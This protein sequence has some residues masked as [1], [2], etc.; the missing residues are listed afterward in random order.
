MRRRNLIFTF[1][2]VLAGTLMNMTEHV[3]AQGIDHVS[4]SGESVA[5]ELR[6]SGVDQPYNLKL[7]PF[8]LR[9]EAGVTT[10]YNDN[11]NLTKTAPMGDLI[12]T[13]TT[14]MHGL[15][16]VSDLNTVAFNIGLGYQ[17]YLSHSEDN[18]I[19]VSPDSEAQFNFFVGDVMFTVHDGF[20]YQQDP[21]Q[22]GQLSNTVRLERFTNDVGIGAKWDL[23]SFVL[24]L[25]YDHTNFWV[26]SSVYDYLTNQ[27]DTVTAKVSYN[28]DKSIQTG[29][30]M[31]VSDTRYEQNF[32]ND[33]RNLSVGP[34]VTATITKSLSVTGQAGGYF[35]TYDKGGGNG[36]SQD[37]NSYYFSLGINHQITQS[38]RE[39]LT[40][41]REFIPGLTTNYTERIYANYTL[42]WQAT[43]YLNAGANL[44]WENL[45]DS[46]GT[47]HETSDRYGLGLS[48]NDSVTEHATLSLNYQY[49]VKN[50]NPSLLSYEQNQVTAGVN[51]QF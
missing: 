1:V 40:A 23:S 10:S 14:T 27:S 2:C 26:T 38:I 6:Q 41:G 12:T 42:T 45:N 7:G 11:I 13:P 8:S 25:D 32:Q 33:N 17:T 46:Q 44:L 49:L 43:T 16:Q 35:T 3:Q 24:S 37:L 18:C 31:S 4:L 9:M 48:L 50:A 5:E 36:D 28:V 39:S 30:S 29:L 34:F 51:Y 21:T 19:L 15:W 47:V 22:I 20:S